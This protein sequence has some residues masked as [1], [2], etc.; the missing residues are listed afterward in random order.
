[1]QKKLAYFKKK[2]YLCSGFYV[3][4][5]SSIKKRNTIFNNIIKLLAQ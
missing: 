3:D 1:M 4:T 2:Q 5:E